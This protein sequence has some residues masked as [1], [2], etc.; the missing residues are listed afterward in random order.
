ML[1]PTRVHV[2]LHAAVPRAEQRAPGF[3]K[4]DPHSPLGS[5]TLRV[6]FPGRRGGHVARLLLGL[7]LLL[8][9]RGGVV[10][11]RPLPGDRRAASAQWRRDAVMAA[12]RRNATAAGTVRLARSDR[13][14]HIF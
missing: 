6:G 14:R 4:I 2:P 3:R 10:R 13:G 1:V 11:G 7:D 12:A 8:S 5:G 9:R